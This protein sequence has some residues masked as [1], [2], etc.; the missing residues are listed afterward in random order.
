MLYLLSFSED[1]VCHFKMLLFCLWAVKT[2]SVISKCFFVCLWVISDKLE[3]FWKKTNTMEGRTNKL[4]NKLTSSHLELLY[5]LSFS[6]EM[7]CQFK[8][9]LFC[10]WVISE[11]LETF[12]KKIYYGRMDERT[13]KQTNTQT[14]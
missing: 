8:M 10:L 4:K 2:C 1:M 14:N 13:D 5:V 11:K 3:T 12:L 9:L 6:E 7:V